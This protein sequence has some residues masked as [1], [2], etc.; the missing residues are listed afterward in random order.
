[1]K[2]RFSNIDPDRLQP[3][4][5]NQT[6]VSREP[7]ILDIIQPKQT[8]LKRLSLEMVGA[9]ADSQWLAATMFIQ[10]ADSAIVNKANE[11]VGTEPDALMAALK[12]N[13]WVYRTINKQFTISIPSAVEVLHT[14][15]GDCNEHTTLYTALARAVGIPTRMCIGMVYANDGFYYHAWPEVFVGEWTPM[16]PTFGQPEVDAT[17]I[18]LLEGDLEQ[19]YELGRIIGKVQ[20]EV[21]ELNGEVVGERE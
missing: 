6:L 4:A 1:M 9:Q 21:L 19:Q 16:D 15:E 7:F 3:E 2:V 10:T 5:V 8:K 14:L 13:D 11:I 17:H 18:K 12:I 20:L